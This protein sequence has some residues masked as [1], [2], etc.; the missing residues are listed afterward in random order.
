VAFGTFLIAKDGDLTMPVE[1]KAF[2]DVD[3]TNRTVRV[4]N[5][6][7]DINLPFSAA[8]MIARTIEQC[9]HAECSAEGGQYEP[10]KD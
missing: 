4:H 6:K 3:F 7:G 10:A 9:L 2:L 8:Y 1:P 5:E